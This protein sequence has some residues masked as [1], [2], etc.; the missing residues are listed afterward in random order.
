L[1][2]L[3]CTKANRQLGW[4][5]VLS[6]DEGVDRTVAWY[7]SSADGNAS[8]DPYELSRKQIAR[9]VETARERGT[10]WAGGS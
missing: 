2:S 3:D 1:L 4:S 9:F 5:P 10:L 7:R 8:C 6:L